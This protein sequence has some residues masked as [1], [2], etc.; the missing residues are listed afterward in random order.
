MVCPAQN[1]DK[2]LS[3]KHLML[4]IK[5]LS[6]DSDVYTEI[7]EE[8]LP[9]MD[10]LKDISAPL[11]VFSILGNH[12]YGDYFDLMRLFKKKHIWIEDTNYY[13]NSSS[14][15][16]IFGSNPGQISTIGV[17]PMEVSRVPDYDK[18]YNDLSIVFRTNS[19]GDL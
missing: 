8:V 2:P 5:K 16:N 6:E 19:F 9:F 18:G 15:V 1:T 13:V 14:D 7:T 17:E 10:V 12:D 11:G 3:P 4:D